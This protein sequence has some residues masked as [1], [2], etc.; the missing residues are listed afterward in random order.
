MAASSAGNRGSNEWDGAKT[1][2]IVQ[3]W[4]V[5]PAVFGRSSHAR[6][7]LGGRARMRR[8]GNA[9][10]MHLSSL[11]RSFAGNRHEP[12]EAKFARVRAGA[13]SP[14]RAVRYAVR[15]RPGFAAV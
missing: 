9:G 1:G 3:D 11:I 5:C 4:A 8:A 15:L 12:F 10:M 7:R 14:V 13:P 2:R 6:M